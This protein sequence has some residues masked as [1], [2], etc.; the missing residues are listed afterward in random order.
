MF[1]RNHSYGHITPSPKR[2]GIM[3]GVPNS[4]FLSAALSFSTLETGLD[5]SWENDLD[6]PNLADLECGLH[7]FIFASYWICALVHLLQCQSNTKK[8]DARC[9]RLGLLLH[10]I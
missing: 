3:I 1:S 10:W 8:H 7:S 6:G 5:G 4:L 9:V 2:K